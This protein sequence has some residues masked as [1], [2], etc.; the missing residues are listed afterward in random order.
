MVDSVDPTESLRRQIEERSARFLAPSVGGQFVSSL[1]LRES[2]AVWQLKGED[3]AS[4]DPLSL[5]VPSGDLHHQFY[6][7][8]HPDAFTVTTT[9]PE[10]TDVEVK[11][12][13]RS[14]IVG[15]LDRAIALADEWIT[16]E[17]EA[18]LLV[19]PSYGVRALWI[20]TASSTDY[21][22]PVSNLPPLSGGTE[23]QINSSA[24]YFD[25]LRQRGPA[26]GLTA[27]QTDR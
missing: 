4:T 6:L 5:A 14:P 20:R 22:I 19:I 15:V 17:G 13:F 24:E 21:L 23:P 18:R 10:G 7:G 1:Q 8:G 3:V 27:R 11:S 25:W 2:F 26:G 12:A 9:N 16:E